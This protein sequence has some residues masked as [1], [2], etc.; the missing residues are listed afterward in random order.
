MLSGL[1]EW[2]QTWAVPQ[3]SSCFTL[4]ARNS[5]LNSPLLSV[6]PTG[7]LWSLE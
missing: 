5:V 3:D 1:G 2:R 4:G 6:E 7:Q